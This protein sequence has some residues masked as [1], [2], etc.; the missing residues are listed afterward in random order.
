MIMHLA[1]IFLDSILKTLL[2]QFIVPKTLMYSLHF[3]V[4]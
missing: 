2:L 3:Q 1:R 4:P